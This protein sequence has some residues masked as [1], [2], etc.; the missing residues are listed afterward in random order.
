MLSYYY[1]YYSFLSK[2]QA[3]MLVFVKIFLLRCLLDLYSLVLW[4]DFVHAGVHDSKFKKK[5]F[6]IT[7]C[8]HTK[9]F[10]SESYRD[11]SCHVGVDA[12]RF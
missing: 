7:A 10:P 8:V 11:T 4:K 5:D 6:S 1:I 12:S 3:K 9:P 2:K